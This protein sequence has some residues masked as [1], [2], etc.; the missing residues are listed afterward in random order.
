M[1]YSAVEIARALGQP[2]PTLEQQQIIEAPLEPLVV[3]AGAGSG[4]TETMSARVIWLIANEK[5]APYEVLGLTFTKK[6]ALE[7]SERIN[8]RLRQLRAVK[9]LPQVSGMANFEKPT[10]STYNAYA[11]GLVSDYAVR[12]GR[13]NS[14]EVITETTRWQL[15]NEVVN[16]WR[17][18]KLPR[19]SEATLT[20]AVLGLAGDCAD[21]LLTPSQAKGKILQVLDQ[22]SGLK[23]AEKS[24]VSLKISY[25]LEYLYQR[26]ELL[27][28]VEIFNQKRWDKDFIDFSDQ[29]SLALEVAQNPQIVSIEKQKYPVVLLDEYQDTSFGQ[30][31]LLSTLF[32][33][34]HAVCAVGDPNQAI[35]GW[36]GASA[37]AIGQFGY[38]FE[39]KDKTAAKVLHLSTSWRNDDAILEVANKTAAPLRELQQEVKTLSSRPGAGPGRVRWVNAG[40]IVEE[41]QEVASLI[42]EAK[43]ASPKPL[44]VAVLCRKRKLFP[45]FEKAL[46][47]AGLEIEVVGLG[48]LLQTPEIV[49]LVSLLTVVHDVG[50][51]GALMRL[52]T[53]PKLA[54]GPRD[55]KVLRDFSRRLTRLFAPAVKNDSAADPGFEI[56]E[57]SDEVTIIEALEY[58]ESHGKDAGFSQVAFARLNWL[59]EKIQYLRSLTYLPLPD[60]ISQCQQVW[61][62]D[63]ELAVLTPSGGHPWHRLDEFMAVTRQYLGSVKV[64]TLGGFLAWLRVSEKQE[65]GFTLPTLQVNP[66]AVQV[67][68]IHAAKGLEWDLVA[69][70]GLNEETFPNSKEE[71][72]TGLRKDLG[73]VT[74]LAQLPYWL[75]G[76]AINLPKID[77]AGIDSEDRLLDAF[78]KFG[79]E[80]GAHMLAEERR[81]AYVAFTRAKRDLI[82]SSSI[83]AETTQPRKD[84]LFLTELMEAKVLGEANTIVVG[85]ENFLADTNPLHREKITALWPNYPQ[86]AGL[87]NSPLTQTLLRSAQVAYEAQNTPATDAVHGDLI[88][89]H[90]VN[91]TQLTGLLL[92]ADINERAPK[93]GLLPEHLSASALV[94]LARDREAYLLDLR[95]PLPSK[96]FAATRRGSEFH[97]WVEDYFEDETMFDLADFEDSRSEDLGAEEMAKLKTNF[98]SSMWS[99]QKPIA[100]EVPID[101]VVGGKIIRT[102]IDAVFADPD[103]EGSVILVDWKTGKEPT[104]KLFEQA[105]NV[106]LS[107]YA[108]AWSRWKNIPLNRIR[109]AFYYAQ[110]NKTV[111]LSH[112]FT[113]TELANLLQ[114]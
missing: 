64:S 33:G 103:N 105:R 113:E 77:F 91:L 44:S 50:S 38:I 49:D 93:V 56:R 54:I 102:R 52:L 65:D 47:E 104:F 10:I 14:L 6:A 86:V 110:E 31:E 35:Y 34:G 1:K 36:R 94:E 43:T 67:L 4:K 97:R 58:L 88:T 90:G 62:L 78:K 87:D 60:L 37:D 24:S 114:N 23:K 29:V 75:R 85:E 111:Y 13:E 72:D 8:K 63:V 12:I 32:G 5:V 61:D 98:E 55:L 89:E 108:L 3:I 18:K 84:S 22:L 21:H 51:T 82:L 2:E 101:T 42:L 17:P 27:D 66:D 59:K 69:V 20:D 106:Q 30:T 107:T 41:A 9:L 45:H 40:T 48:G 95:R 92:A 16:K 112:L 28:L 25:Y 53:S 73:W 99:K 79:Y 76:D 80:N 100:V 57:P 15:A 68:T 7:L 11:S 96:P 39:R 70:V 19:W 26:A 46:L 109:A 83:W 81:L 71:G 74:D